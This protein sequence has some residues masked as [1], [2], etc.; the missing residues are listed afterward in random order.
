[1]NA[2]SSPYM[3]SMPAAQWAQARTTAKKIV[4]LGAIILL[5]IGFLYALRGN[6][7]V[8]QAPQVAPKE[9]LVSF[10]TPAPAPTQ[11]KQEPVPPKVV[12]I[13]KKRPTV[14]PPPIPITPTPAPTAISEPP[15]PPQEATPSPP[16]EAVAPAPTPAAPSEPGLPKQ[17]TSGIEYISPPVVR[18]P[19]ISRR[20]GEEGTVQFK[21]LVNTM[22]KAER[23]DILKSS[24][25][26]Q[27][28]EEAKRAVMHAVF[29]PYIEN[30]KAIVVSTTG[31]IVFKLDH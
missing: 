25:S 22:G 5:H 15:A 27:L 4:P 8:Q 7:F 12:P 21:V 3:S 11:P 6:L 1:M 17:I 26:S 30:G 9:V 14:K 20:I 13:V 31:A 29:K 2:L 10:I 23:V 24:G 19:A 16:V 28:D 18:Y